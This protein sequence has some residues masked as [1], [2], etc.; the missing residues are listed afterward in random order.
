MAAGERQGSDQIQ[1]GAGV[2]T[3]CSP[4]CT[5]ATA[6]G[7]TPAQLVACRDP[8]G[9]KILRILRLRLREISVRVWSINKMITEI[10]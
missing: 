1:H 2:H 3:G 8:S 6:V 7:L 5:T 10:L 4:C 9:S